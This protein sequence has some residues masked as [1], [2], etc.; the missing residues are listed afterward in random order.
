MEIVIFTGI[1]GFDLSKEAYEYLIYKK[2][3]SVTKTKCERLKNIS[4]KLI[5]YFN[6]EPI[7][8]D[9]DLI[10][11]IDGVEDLSFYETVRYQFNYW[12]HDPESIEIRTNPDVIE[13]IKMLGIN[14]GEC[15]KI[16]EI[17][18]GIQFYIHRCD[19]GSEQ[20]HEKH[21]IWS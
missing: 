20:I 15:L 8:H 3:W 19:D 17:P 12:K 5:D 4:G 1:G 21:R 14:A 2:N 10:D 16:I 7:N 18:D 13:S 11:Y 9:A 6:D